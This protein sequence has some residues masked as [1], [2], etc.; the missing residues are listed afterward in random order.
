MYALGTK[1]QCK[2][3]V[4]VDG[5]KFPRVAQNAG[6]NILGTQVALA[7]RTSKEMEARVAA[8]R[9]KFHER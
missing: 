4:D 6:F 3:N 9:A 5:V 2:K 7:G 1:C 8:V